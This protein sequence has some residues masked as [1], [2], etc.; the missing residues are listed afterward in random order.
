MYEPAERRYYMILGRNLLTTL[1]MDINVYE[2]AIFGGG[3]PY[4][5]LLAPMDN[6]IKYVFIYLTNKVVKP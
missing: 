1:V 4:E 6:L 2:R 3:G 5:R